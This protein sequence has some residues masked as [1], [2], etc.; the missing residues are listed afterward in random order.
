MKMYAVLIL[1]LICSFD[2]VFSQENFSVKED[3]HNS[4]LV[5]HDNEYKPLLNEHLNESTIYFR[6]DANKFLGNSLH[7][8]SSNN[9]FLFINGK[10]SGEYVGEV[11]L[12]LDSISTAHLTSQLL[13]TV[14][15]R[16]INERDLK[17]EI[18]STYKNSK[19]AINNDLKPD[20]FFKDFVIFAGLLIIILFLIVLRLNPKLASDYFSVAK[21]FSLR[22]GDDSQSNARLTSSTNIPFYILAS[23]LLGFYLMIVLNHLPEEYSLP[24]RFQAST[25]WGEIGQWLKISTIIFGIFIMKIITVFTLTR[26]FDMKG[27]ARIHFFNWV[28]L[29]LI[30]FGGA[31]II[32]FV[33]F[34]LRGQSTIFFVVFLT[35]IIISLIGWIIIAFFKLKG[36]G[37]HSMFH[38]FSYICATEIIPLLITVKVLFQ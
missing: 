33:Y 5:Y 4:W 14:H 35:L 13:V 7:L 31:T 16:S 17:T 10:L 29:L 30:I 2:H 37:E 32:L 12:K 3:L 26:L 23:I 20:T 38:L 36:R 19:A 22:E 11:F 25:F 8:V 6:L 21:I 18:V 28:R 34:I 27:T 9:Y 1:V 24:I 15:Q